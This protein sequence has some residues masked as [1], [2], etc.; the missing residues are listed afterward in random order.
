MQAFASSVV[1]GIALG[2]GGILIVAVMTR[3]FGMG[4]CN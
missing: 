4:I 2:L 1:T 3:L